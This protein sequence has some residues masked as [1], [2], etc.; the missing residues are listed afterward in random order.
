[1]TETTPHL[2]LPYIASAQAQKHITV[3]SA[4]SRLDAITQIGVMS[5]EAVNPPTSP[6]NGDRYIIPDDVASTWLGQP[7]Q[8][9]SYQDGYWVYY[10]PKPGWR[11]FAMDTKTNLIFETEMWKDCSL[12]GNA[13]LDAVSI[14]GAVLDNSI[15]LSV[16]A[17]RTLFNAPE[18]GSTAGDVRLLINKQASANKA[19]IIFQTDYMGSAELGLCG[20]NDFHLR[21]S[22]DGQNFTDAFV[23]HTDGRICIGEQPPSAKLSVDGSIRPGNV[24]SAV[25][26][27]PA[28]SGAGAILFSPN[29]GANGHLV[30]SDGINWRSV[31]SGA[32]V[33]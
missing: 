27:N 26:P 6:S 9:A 31:V 23:A 13:N 17:S 14:G 3:N 19:S 4:L 1:M 29:V 10:S 8:L 12:S 7:Q 5:A 21:V 18:E 15:P 30:F 22:P 32:I 16:R 25:L 28:D 2:N 20:D 11:A 33:A 24:S